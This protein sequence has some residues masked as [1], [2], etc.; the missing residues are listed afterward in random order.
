MAIVQR[1]ST[2]FFDARNGGID[3]VDRE[4]NMIDTELHRLPLN[5]GTKA[6]DGDIQPAVGQ[7]DTVLCG[8]DLFEAE[9]LF[10]ERSGFFQV[11]GADRNVFDLS[12]GFAPYLG[13]SPAKHILIDTKGTQ[14]REG[15]PRLSFRTKREIF[16]GS[17]T[18]CSG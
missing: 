2:E 12:H 17:L 3:I 10:V 15:S 4:P 6:Q 5:N 14:S 9:C 16:L 7:V 11:V 18:F 8:T 1:F 13:I